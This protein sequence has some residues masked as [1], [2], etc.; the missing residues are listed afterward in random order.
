[1]LPRC[2]RL[3]DGSDFARVRSE[4]RSWSNPLLV[5]C[6]ARNGLQVTRLGFSVSRRIGNAVTRNR[7][8][9]LIREAVRLQY[10]VIEPGWDVVLIARR[11]IVGADFAEVRQAVNDLVVRARLYSD[12]LGPTGVAQNGTT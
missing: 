8:K 9:R 11:P 10:D 2:A 7:V 6:V 1:M 5:L 12:D 3:T 4:G